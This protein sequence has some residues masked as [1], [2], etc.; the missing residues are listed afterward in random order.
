M[1][2]TKRVIKLYHAFTFFFSLLFWAPIFYEY[3]KQMGLD[4]GQILGIQSLYYL[5]FCLL[6]LPTGYLADR[7]GQRWSLRWAAFFLMTAN[8]IPILDASYHGFLFHWILVALAR[9]MMSGSASAY[10]YDYLE[11]SGETEWYRAT[12][13]RAYALS[14]LG[15]VAAWCAVGYL[16][17]WHLTLPYW[18]T[19]VAGLVAW[20][21]SGRFPKGEARLGEP[22][23][24]AAFR[25]LAHTPRLW[26]VMGAGLSIFVLARLVQINLFQPLL[27]SKNYTVAGFGVVMGLTTL[28]EAAASAWAEP[29]LKRFGEL[30]SIFWVGTAMACATALLPSSGW[31]GSFVLL[32]VIALACG[33]AYPAQRKLL[34]DAIPAAS[35]RSSLMSVES[36]IDRLVCSGMAAA[37]AVFMERG[38][39][40]LALRLAGGLS[41]A[42]SAGLLYAFARH[43]SEAS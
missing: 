33:V 4:D 25:A 41:L 18:L 19:A 32:S 5:S 21:I 35:I 2:D 16:M 42:V 23:L 28:V 27:A 36:L 29:I 20:L 30:P 7:Y 9:S 37:A 17:E 13:G 43:K 24:K 40:D 39:L 14:L 31:A 8:L 11:K 26:L 1:T 15:R 38:E 10:L 22:S 12:E 34:N 3:Q 6:E